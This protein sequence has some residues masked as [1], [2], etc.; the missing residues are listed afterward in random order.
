MFRIGS[1]TLNGQSDAGG[2]LERP[3]IVEPESSQPNPVDINLAN[4][5][6]S[7]ELLLGGSTIIQPQ[8]VSQIP[9]QMGAPSEPKLETSQAISTDIGLEDSDQEMIDQFFAQMD[10]VPTNAGLDSEFIRRFTRS[11]TNNS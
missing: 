10:T 8:N 6:S 4:R 3:T 2:S 11:Q 7:G 5:D 9:I 1:S